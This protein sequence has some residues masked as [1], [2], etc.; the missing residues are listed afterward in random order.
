MVLKGHIERLQPRERFRAGRDATLADAIKV[1]LGAMG[2][3][4]EHP[5]VSTFLDSSRHRVLPV[6]WA[7]SHAAR[8]NLP[9]N[10]C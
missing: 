8:A 10:A 9:D 7:H 2:D 4:G 6:P 1:A 5:P 3:V